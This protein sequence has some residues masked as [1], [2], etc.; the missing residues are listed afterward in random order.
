MNINNQS[1]RWIQYHPFIQKAVYL[2]SIGR[3]TAFLLHNHSKTAL[4]IWCILSPGLFICPLSAKAGNNDP[5]GGRSA[6][7]ANASVTISDEW[8]SF[9]NQAGLGFVTNP[10]IGLY[11]ENRFQVKEFSMKAG[12]CVYPL[13]PASLAL[14]FRHFGYSKYYESKLGLGIGR[15]FTDYFAMGVQIDFLQTYYAEGY[16]TYNVLAAEA[17]LIAIPAK[18]LTLGFH[19][20]NFT[21]N[22]NYSNPEEMIPT[23]VRLGIAYAIEEK[24]LIA[25]EAEKEMN[26]NLMIKAGLE[27]NPVDNLFFR[28]GFATQIEQYSVGIGYR[29][30]KFNADLAFSHNAILGFSPKVSIGFGL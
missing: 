10:T 25:L 17:G 26:T 19:V 5:I 9:N 30:K 23:N 14:S 6:G 24:A 15:K 28:L 27:L 1:F 29:I 13:K 8:S 2:F 20:F 12:T 3:N 4:Y 16:G 11:F 18:N 22:N 7:L 21:R